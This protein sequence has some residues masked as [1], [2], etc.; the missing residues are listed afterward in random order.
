VIAY[1]YSDSCS[2]MLH[3]VSA[4]LVTSPSSIDSPRVIYQPCH[5]FIKASTIKGAKEI[6]LQ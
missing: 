5:P 2:A 3:G 6:V 4:S 1:I